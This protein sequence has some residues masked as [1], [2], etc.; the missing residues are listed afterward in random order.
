[1]PLTF[2]PSPNIARMK[3]SGTIAVASKAR[4]LKAAGRAIID[5][6]AGEPDFDTP[7]FIR[8]AAVEALAAGATRYT[9]TEGIPALREAIAADANRLVRAGP[10]VTAAE[11]VVS[12]GSKQSLYNA[13]VCCF[14]PGDEVLVPTPAWTSYYEMLDLARATVVPVFGLAANSLKVTAAQLEAAATPR[15]RGLML[16][17]PSNPTGA[18]Y[19]SDE[20]TAILTLASERG[21][22]VIADEIYVRIAYDAPAD[23][24]LALAP[25]RDNLIVINGVAKAYAMT[26][27]RIGWCIAPVAVSK[28]MTAFQSHTT[29]NAAAVSQ[30]AA[31]AALGMREQADAAVA[32]MVAEFHR[33]RDA[34]LEALRAFPSV[35]YVHPAGA[36]YLYVNVAGFDGAPDAG[37]AFATRV[38]EQHDVAVVPG[39]AF[40][41]PDWIRA[42]YATSQAVAV[43]GVTRIARCLTGV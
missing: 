20:L 40:L 38:L 18:V 33:R 30:H 43:E 4:A 2:Q 29:S 42:S 5:L 7:L 17:S 28:A 39:N 3:E 21:W 26:G 36:F 11:V 35:R 23:S 16:C 32:Y 12:N 19:S 15:T 34:V 22:W 6:G 24:A 27:W 31:L 41:T 8:Q 14:G 9:A 37:A 25:S 10:P 13:C 1:M